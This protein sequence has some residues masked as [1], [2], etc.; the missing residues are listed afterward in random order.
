MAAS[1]AHEGSDAAGALVTDPARL[2]EVVSAIEAAG[3]FAL[4]LEFVS[5]DRY[6]P[7]LALVQVAWGD[8]A[9]PSI[10]AVD[11]LAVDPSP[12]LALVARPD[13]AD[14]SR[15]L[16]RLRFSRRFPGPTVDTSA[17][18]TTPTFPGTR[19]A[20]TSGEVSATTPTRSR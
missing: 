17:R 9:R 16:L 5:E 12:L 13:V 18:S 4:D 1:P 3:R 8:A 2:A 10:A 20:R 11:P 7:D 15:Q 14:S 19:S 6:V